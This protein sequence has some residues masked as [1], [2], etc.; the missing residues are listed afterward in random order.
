[1]TIED[2]ERI[3]DKVSEVVSECSQHWHCNALDTVDMVVFH[4]EEINHDIP[5][6]IQDDLH[7]LA[8]LRPLHQCIS[9][10]MVHWETKLSRLEAGDRLSRENGGRPKKAINIELV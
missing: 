10:L 5:A 1:M 8:H 3:V 7:S 2:M 6:Y 4:L 9:Q